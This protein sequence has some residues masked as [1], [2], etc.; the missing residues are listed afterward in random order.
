ME[1]LF[2]GLDWSEEKHDVCIING[3]GARL[4]EFIIG[5]D[6]SGQKRLAK[7]I[8]A[9]SLPPEQCHIALETAHNLVMDFI[10]SRGYTPFVISPNKVASSRGRFSSS[11]RRND[12][13][14]AHLLADMLR[15][16]E[17]RFA[18]WRADGIVINQ[19][20]SS[21]R[22]IDDLTQSITRYSNR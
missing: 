2:I 21:L 5:T 6:P 9:F 7:E 20:K 17:N 16:D 11:G 22:L 3:S 15:T 19:L 4:K 10:W 14:D 12:T 18:P 8:D 13:S 1:T